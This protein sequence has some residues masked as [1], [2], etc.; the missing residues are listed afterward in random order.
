MLQA[1]QWLLTRARNLLDGPAVRS[2]P[3]GL[4][5]DGG[6]FQDRVR[7]LA[8]LPEADRDLLR[9]AGAKNQWHITFADTYEEAQRLLA[10][11]QAPVVLCDR[12]LAQDWWS[13]VEGL[14][15]CSRQACILLVSKVADDYL[16]NELVR[17]GG[18]D[19]LSK[20]L[21]EA[22]LV[23]AVRL[24]WTYWSSTNRRQPDEGQAAPFKNHSAKPASPPTR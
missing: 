19:V 23:R 7:I 24:A 14:A 1:L 12:D 18:Y 2:S 10:K 8:V 5:R 11:V 9:A 20:P 17:R 13:M 6:T 21:E 3:G 22:E 4:G 16:W 15:A